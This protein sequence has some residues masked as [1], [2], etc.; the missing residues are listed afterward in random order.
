MRTVKHKECIVRFLL[1]KSLSPNFV[2]D[3]RITRSASEVKIL[4]GI[5]LKSDSDKYSTEREKSVEGH[6]LMIEIPSEEVGV[7]DNSLDLGES[8]R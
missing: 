6:E 1:K 4:R 7:T 5:K 3:S 2:K 8:R